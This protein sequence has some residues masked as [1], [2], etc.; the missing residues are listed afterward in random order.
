MT[1][2]RG[3]Y[4][5]EMGITV[6]EGGGDG[7]GTDHEAPATLTKVH[8]AV[9]PSHQGDSGD[10][11]GKEE[12]QRR[13][14]LRLPEGDAGP[15]EWEMVHFPAVQPWPEA[16]GGV[17]AV[18]RR[19]QGGWDGGWGHASLRVGVA[20]G[21]CGLPS[22]SQF[23]QSASLTAGRS[24]ITERHCPPARDFSRLFIPVFSICVRVAA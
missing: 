4:L 17:R 20:L 11:R 22:L 16:A 15:W 18:E 14:I 3:E 9:S 1:F 19:E 23:L 7:V 10:I 21:G 6:T 8:S 12:S 24:S 2:L 5:N 13:A